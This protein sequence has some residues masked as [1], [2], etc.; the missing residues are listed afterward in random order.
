MCRH[1]QP[2]VGSDNT[3]PNGT[4]DADKA[5]DD[6]ADDSS[7]PKALGDGASDS[8]GLLDQVLAAVAGL[9]SQ[10]E[11]EALSQRLGA[12]A[13][14]FVVQALQVRGPAQPPP[15]RE[16]SLLAQLKHACP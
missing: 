5:L 11:L 15:D 9:A 7:G 1:R 4:D 3:G 10:Q 13:D 16:A 6:G 8:S 12:K 14:L 2:K